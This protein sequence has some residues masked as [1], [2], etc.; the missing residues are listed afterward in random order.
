MRAEAREAARE[1]KKRELA[2]HALDA[3]AELGFAR[4]NL[5]EIAARSGLSLGRI[6]YYFADRTELLIVSV[7]LYKD[8]FVKRIEAEIARAATADEAVANFA[9]GLAQSVADDAA[10]HRLWY[11]VRAQ[12]MYDAA[13]HAVVDRLEM[14]LAG[15]VEQLFAQVGQ[16][17]G[18][19]VTSDP[20][21]AYLI[22][23]GWFQHFLRHR[24][25]GDALTVDD[26]ARLITSELEAAL[27][28]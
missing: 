12:A 3:L 16:L 18:R 7:D 17:R 6:H 28:A 22:I 9:T 2:W 23:D 1:A 25:A 13:F 21:R 26:M 11:D 5:R 10:T 27:S 15:V 8:R 19:P 24:L 20:F 14:R 4:V